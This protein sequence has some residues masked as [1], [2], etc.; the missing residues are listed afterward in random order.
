MS[1][2]NL[3]RSTSEVEDEANDIDTSERRPEVRRVLSERPLEAGKV[4]VARLSIPTC[5]VL[6]DCVVNSSPKIEQDIKDILDALEAP[7]PITRTPYPIP[8]DLPRSPL[9]DPAFHEARNKHKAPKAEVTVGKPG[10]LQ[11]RLAKNPF[12]LMLAQPT[13]ECKIVQT[14]KSGLLLPKFFLQ[15][16]GLIKHPHSRQ[17]WY[18]PMNL[19][20]H[21]ASRLPQLDDGGGE[22]ST[23]ECRPKHTGWINYILSSK[24]MLDSIFM[25]TPK[26]TRALNTKHLVPQRILRIPETYKTIAN[27]GFRQDMSTFLLEIWRRRVTEQLIYLKSLPTSYLFGCKSWEQALKISQVGCFIYTGGKH[28]LPGPPTEFS[29]VDVKCGQLD[30]DGKPHRISAEGP[31]KTKKVPVH[32]FR[33]LLGERKLAHL[34]TRSSLWYKDIVAVKAKG[35]T[36]KLRMELWKLE[37]YLARYGWDDPTPGD[38]DRAKKPIMARE[39]KESEDLLKNM[40]K[41]E[42]DPDNGDDGDVGDVV[43]DADQED[44]QR[45][46]II[47]R[48][49][50][51]GGGK[52]VPKDVQK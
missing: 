24:L 11:A 39:L 22:I 28:N 25:G 48:L 49:K 33:V 30:E 50:E 46:E 21:K 3:G 52:T 44:V 1:G 47:Q 18:L 19:E 34:R 37:G 8:Y 36:I 17:P 51:V 23:P 40:P 29:T 38:L 7:I 41:C 9:M 27:A 13:R 32:D 5:D 26:E 12:A 20:Q 2:S 43:D 31:W 6:P 45:R 15:A 16:F 42:D 14:P 10:S 4:P 35:N